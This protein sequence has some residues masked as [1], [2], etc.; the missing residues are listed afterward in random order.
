MNQKTKLTVSGI[1]QDLAN[2]LTRTSNSKNYNA[3]IGCIQDKYDLSNYDLDMLFRHPKLKG[4]KTHAVKLTS[5]I[6]EDDVDVDVNE[7]VE[8]TQ[9]V[10]ETAVEATEEVEQ[11]DEYVKEEIAAGNS[12]PLPVDE[13]PL[14]AGW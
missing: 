7:T 14:N 9:E 10:V 12:H 6:L 1:L 8:T 13:D 4:R 3:E 2:G 11:V 5:F